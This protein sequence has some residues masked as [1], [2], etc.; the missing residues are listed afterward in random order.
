VE[1]HTDPAG[2]SV[3]LGDRSCVS[4]QCR[5]DLAPGR[6]SVEA[7]L[8][9]YQPV[10]RDLDVDSSKPTN[11]I[12]LSLQP[13]HVE[14]PASAA[15]GTLVVQT[16]VPDAL[17][18][19]D[20]RG[21][22]RSSQAGLLQLPIEAKLHTVRVE[23]AGYQAAVEQRVEVPKDGS[24]TV[25][26]KLTPLEAKLQIQNAP[27][28]AELRM[29]GALRGKTNGSAV[30]SIAV[31]AGQHHFQVTLSSATSQFDQN[32]APGQQ[33][34]IDWPKI[35][36]TPLPPAVK[37]QPQPVVPAPDAQA[38]EHLRD[39]SDTVQ[40]KAFVD[41]Y[42][43]SS[44]AEEARQRIQNT[45]QAARDQAAKDQA[46][47]EQIAKDQ[48]LKEQAAKDQALREQA[49]R[50]QAEKQKLAGAPPSP[51]MQL[52]IELFN[53]AFRHR[54][55]RELK[56]IWP[57][58]NA[59]YLE[60]ARIGGSVFLQATGAAVVSGDKATVPCQ[61]ISGGKSNPVQVTLQKRGEGWIIV[62][63]GR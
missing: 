51:G 56:A 26:F 48:V 8:D 14:V 63:I 11:A 33:V 29:D 57:T 16:G 13:I 1:I 35:D 3:K 60:S 17:V 2:A 6:Y 18:F 50:E 37:P 40:L 45:A 4:P 19:I 21:R 34:A 43:G 42:P 23:K 55:P 22:G 47:R 52:T 53:D 54:K 25:G 32:F 10:Q 61:L 46:L 24:R 41:K 20:N 5:F 7:R 38:W 15:T 9:G 62:D 39:S 31:P 44:H 36:P 30:F 58:S 12:D 27:P 59:I 28:G 49:A